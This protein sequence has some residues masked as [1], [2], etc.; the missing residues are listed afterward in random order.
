GDR[1]RAGSVQKSGGTPWRTHL[2]GIQ[3]RRRLD[4]LFHA[5]QQP[6]TQV[7]RFG[8]T[9]RVMLRIAMVEDDPAEA[10]M[11]QMALRQGSPPPEIVLLEDGMQVL[12]YLAGD[13]DHSH[14][15]DLVLLDLNLPRLSGFEVLERIRADEHLRSLPVVLMSGSV[16]PAEVERGYRLG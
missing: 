6:E 8:S 9:R 7:T 5:A 16:D 11:L 3:T 12:E 10:Q 4:F 13:R 2:G 14:L 15:C 1:Y